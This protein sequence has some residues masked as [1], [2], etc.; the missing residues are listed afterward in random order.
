MIFIGKI[1]PNLTELSIEA[2]NVKDY[3]FDF[4]DQRYLKR[5]ELRSSK[6]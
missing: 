5:V 1:M 3:Q 6:E 2:D 4:K